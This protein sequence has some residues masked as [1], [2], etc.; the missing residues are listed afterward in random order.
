MLG[1]VCRACVTS[2]NV[3]C[4]QQYSVGKYPPPHDTR[5]AGCVCHYYHCSPQGSVL[6]VWAAFLTTATGP[7]AVKNC[8]LEKKSRLFY[9][10]N[11]CLNGAATPFPTFFQFVLASSSWS[12]RHLNVAQRC[13][14]L[15]KRSNCN[16]GSGANGRMELQWQ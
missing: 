10:I 15:T 1:P 13:S 9:G 7:P 11:E 8:E 6:N 2:G 16:G 3:A 4:L 5:C 14:T 12:N